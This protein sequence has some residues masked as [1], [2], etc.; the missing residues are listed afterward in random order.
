MIAKLMRLQQLDQP[1]VVKNNFILMVSV[2]LPYFT[3]TIILF[4]LFKKIL[5]I[6]TTSNILEL[7]SRFF[8]FAIYIV[9]WEK[10]GNDV[11]LW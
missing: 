2:T 8:L 11:T 9:V 3:T 5:W 4:S 6:S 1:L 7:K 10:T